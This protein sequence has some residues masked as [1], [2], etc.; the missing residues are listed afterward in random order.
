[1]AIEKLERAK[2]EWNKKRTERLDFLNERII[3]ERN[4]VNEFDDVDQAM[5]LYYNITGNK[6]ADLPPEPKLSDFYTPSKDHQEREIAFVV[7]GIVL[8]GFVA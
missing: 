1:M 4:A 2:E 6:L 8:T 7:G 5:R 3:K